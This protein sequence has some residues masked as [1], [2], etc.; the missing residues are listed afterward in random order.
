MASANPGVSA[1]GEAAGRSALNPFAGPAAIGGML[2]PGDEPDVEPSEQMKL[3]AR[4]S[5]AVS[6]I[7]KLANAM[8][9][10]SI[11][12]PRGRSVVPEMS[13]MRRD[14][15]GGSVT[16]SVLDSVQGDTS[17]HVTRP[18]GT[19]A[20]AAH[21]LSGFSRMAHPT[22]DAQRQAASHYRT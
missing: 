18:A 8:E 9:A 10:L 20:E 4:L 3:H 1:A 6:D 17:G 14:G 16:P 2:V 12:L 22:S 5:T 13:D 19:A 11:N 21:T 15:E 7:T